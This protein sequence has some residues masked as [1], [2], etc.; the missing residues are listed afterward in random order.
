MGI[1]LVHRSVCDIVAIFRQS[2]AVGRIE[3][4]HLL[5]SHIVRERC[6]VGDTLHLYAIVLWSTPLVVPQID[7]EID[8][9]IT[10]DTPPR[11]FRPYLSS[12]QHHPQSP[13]RDEYRPELP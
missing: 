1:V 8:I 4:A 3:Y 7:I 9:A 11:G 12:W 6:I 5:P 13:N 10:V 2:G